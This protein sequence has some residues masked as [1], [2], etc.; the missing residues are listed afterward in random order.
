MKISFVDETSC[1]CRI[2]SIRMFDLSLPGP[3][4]EETIPGF[5]A[6]LHG[7]RLTIPEP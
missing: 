4:V 2:A 5:Q 1:G 6:T 3:A 7:I